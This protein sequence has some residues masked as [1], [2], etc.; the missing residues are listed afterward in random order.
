MLARKDTIYLGNEWSRVAARIWDRHKSKI[1]ATTLTALVVTG[2]S[3]PES[4]QPAQKGQ[5]AAAAHQP[6][7]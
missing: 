3:E 1:V 7:P 5:T 2:M 4:G 6:K